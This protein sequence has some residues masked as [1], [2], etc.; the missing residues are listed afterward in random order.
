MTVP[1][2]KAAADAAAAVDVPDPRLRVPEKS[3]LT[4]REI[5][6]TC[7]GEK[8]C[9]RHVKRGHADLGHNSAP[10]SSR[11]PRSF[12]QRPVLQFVDA[13]EAEA[14]AEVSST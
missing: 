3:M 1:L 9:T 2:A 11:V 5:L 7:S 4:P 14:H 13:E 12:T 10:I 8:S 6:V